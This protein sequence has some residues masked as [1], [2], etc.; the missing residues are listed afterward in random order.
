MQQTSS[1]TPTSSSRLLSAASPAHTGLRHGQR[2]AQH[3]QHS[4]LPLPVVAP[5]ARQ[6]INSAVNVQSQITNVPVYPI[7]WFGELNDL[8]AQYHNQFSSQRQQYG[9]G[10]FQ[11][12]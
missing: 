2:L 12:S 3:N 9:Q 11:G 5:S 7:Q 4:N 10:N 6:M 1:D 8:A